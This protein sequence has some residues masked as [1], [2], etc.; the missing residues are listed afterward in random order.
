MTTGSRIHL[1]RCADVR[2]ACDV[3]RR[4]RLLF[5]TE[6]LVRNVDP[7]RALG[8]RRRLPVLCAGRRRTDIANDLA[9]HRLLVRGVAQSAG[10]QV[11]ALAGR[12][13]HERR[14]RHYFAR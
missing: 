13:V 6:I 4:C 11:D 8:V 14:R 5:L 10:L 1:D 3:T 9:D 7:S 12:D 2:R